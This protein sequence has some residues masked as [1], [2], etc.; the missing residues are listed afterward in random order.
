MWRETAH[1]TARQSP[2]P[3]CLP[4]VLWVTLG[5]VPPWCPPPA[6]A[7]PQPMGAQLLPAS[8]T[9]D[10]PP[11]TPH[12]VQLLLLP[13]ACQNLQVFETLVSLL[14][15]AEAVRQQEVRGRGRK[16]DGGVVHSHS[17]KSHFLREMHWKCPSPRS[18]E[19]W[20]SPVNL[21][22]F[23]LG[24]SIGIRLV[25]FLC[26]ELLRKLPSPF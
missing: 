4:A 17:D 19:A 22:A 24:Y 14:S 6:E 3:H 10:A 9:R 15:W 1:T 20:K 21:E 11:A 12:H 26:N 18:T 23:I 5:W 25:G 7:W 16:G 8:R 13:G 2:A